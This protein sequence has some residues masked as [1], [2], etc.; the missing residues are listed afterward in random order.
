MNHTIYDNCKKM[1]ENRPD[2]RETKNIRL[3]VW[4][5][6]Q[7]FHG[8]TEYVNYNRWCSLP[9]PDTLTRIFRKVKED[10]PL[11]RG[12][13]KSQEQRREKEYKTKDDLGYSPLTN[14]HHRELAEQSKLF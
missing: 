3:S 8:I 13:E 2:M 10:Y 9:Q 5:Y 4:L 1:L 6:W 12:S 7:E 11:L 14:Q